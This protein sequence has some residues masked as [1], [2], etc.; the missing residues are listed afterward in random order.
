MSESLQSERG[1]ALIEILV[2]MIVIGILAVIAI[3]SFLSQR[4]KGQDTCAKSQIH[5]MATALATIYTEDE[6]YS[7]ADLARLHETESSIV[8]SGGCGNGTV[9]V[10]GGLSSGSCDPAAGPTSNTFCV[11]QTS[12][13]G[14]TFLLAQDATG[15]LHRTC[16]PLGGGCL[17]GTW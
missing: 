4:S 1:F 8:T 14:R 7:G 5:A 12:G 10:S 11:S 16:A 13:S 9:A 3:P 2:V 15:G 6:S 17:K